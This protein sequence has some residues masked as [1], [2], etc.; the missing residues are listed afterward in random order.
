MKKDGR[1]KAII[2]KVTAAERKDFRRTAKSMNRTVSGYVRMLHAI[3]T[4]GQKGGTN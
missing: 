1:D 3:A 4:K 2:F